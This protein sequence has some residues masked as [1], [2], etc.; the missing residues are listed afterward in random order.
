MGWFSPD[1]PDIGDRA[2]AFSLRNHHGEDVTAAGLSGAPML[3]F[4]YP[5]AFTTVCT[6]EIAGLVER[7]DQFRA[8]G[9]RVLAISTDT[10]FSLRAFADAEH[11][12]FDLVSDHWPHGRAAK[13]YGVFDEKLGCARR[14]SFLVD[15]AGMIA[16]RAWA[17]LP[18][19][20]DLD[21]HVEAARALR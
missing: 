12:P 20:R 16:W 3:L 19:G 14:G 4:F 6:S 11:V 8:V 1:G 15:A 9:C 7:H 10:M 17:E 5:Y 18:E 2:P 13:A 21:G